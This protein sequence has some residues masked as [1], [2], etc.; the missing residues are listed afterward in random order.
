MSNDV[1]EQP[2]TTRKYTEKDIYKKEEMDLLDHSI[3][4]ISKF[5]SNNNDEHKIAAMSIEKSEAVLKY[6][7]S[8][9]KLVNTLANN[10]IKLIQMDT[11]SNDRGRLMTL[12][13][14]VQLR[15]IVR[16]EPR[17]IDVDIE[18]GVLDTIVRGEL[19][20]GVEQL[21][22]KLL[23]LERENDDNNLL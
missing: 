18:D 5:I 19:T 4:I 22:L 7:D 21:S 9:V 16:D 1:I 14:N 13:N 17:V 3:S 15:N 11:D 6:I 2:Q 23:D 12:L 8:G 20:E 10:R